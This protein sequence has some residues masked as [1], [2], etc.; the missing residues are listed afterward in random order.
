MDGYTDL[1]ILVINEGYVHCTRTRKLSKAL[2]D[3]VFDDQNMRVIRN[4][5]VHF[6]FTSLLLTI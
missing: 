6:N 2:F 4:I 1:I 5:V 3:L